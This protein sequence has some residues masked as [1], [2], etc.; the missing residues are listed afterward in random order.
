MERL[1]DGFAGPN[2][3]E[4]HGEVRSGCAPPRGNYTSQGNALSSSSSSAM[5]FRWIGYSPGV[6]EGLY[7]SLLTERL[8][9]A[10]AARPDL[11]AD[12]DAVDEAEQPLTIA[13]HLTPLIERSL[14]AAATTEQG[15]GRGATAHACQSALSIRSSPFM[16]GDCW[17]IAIRTSRSLTGCPPRCQPYPSC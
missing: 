13:R 12:I 9:R 15:S 7:E 16:I 3:C 1:A 10:L 11:R 17:A 5:P 8:S 4:R 14:R 2:D 6:E